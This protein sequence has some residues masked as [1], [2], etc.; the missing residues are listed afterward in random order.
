VKVQ[1]LSEST[2]HNAGRENCKY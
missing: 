2:V 1:D